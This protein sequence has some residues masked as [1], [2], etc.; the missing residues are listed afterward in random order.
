MLSIGDAEAFHALTFK[1]F[2]YFVGI[3]TAIGFD[4]FFIKNMVV[5]ILIPQKQPYEPRHLKQNFN[6]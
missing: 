1:E 3:F 4:S 5:G 6:N 2:L